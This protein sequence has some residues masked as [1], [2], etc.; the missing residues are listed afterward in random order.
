VKYFWE[1][2]GLVVLFAAAIFWAEPEAF[3]DR[4]GR[5]MAAFNAAK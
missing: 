1:V 2:M 3:G 5:F 4:A